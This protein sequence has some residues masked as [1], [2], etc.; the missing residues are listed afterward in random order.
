M[1]RKALGIAFLSGVLLCGLGCGVAFAQY[2]K[3]EYAGERIIGGENIVKETLE[4]E[5]E[6]EGKILI[7]SYYTTSYSRYGTTLETD[8]NIPKNK[9]IFDI[10]YNPERFAPAV[11]RHTQ[12]EDILLYGTEIVNEYG[13]VIDYREEYK[14]DPE[15][16]IGEVYELG[17]PKYYDDVKDFF[18]VKDMVL[19]DIKNGKLGNYRVEYIESITVRV[20]PANADRVEFYY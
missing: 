11:E 9:I 15:K 18:E 3:M 19:S 1:N 12:Y 14:T 16:V 13:E 6:S 5:L 7:P 2:S 20:N 8:E 17:R 4:A 10:E